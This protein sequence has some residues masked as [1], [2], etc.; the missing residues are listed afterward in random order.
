MAS[1][2]GAEARVSGAGCARDGGSPEPGQGSA[3]GAAALPLDGRHCV[4]YSNSHTTQ[5]L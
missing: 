5:T 3:G 4:F 2:A 1:G